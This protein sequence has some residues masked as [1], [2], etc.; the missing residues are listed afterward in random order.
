VGAGGSINTDVNFNAMPTGALTGN[1]YL[2]TDGVSLSVTGTGLVTFGQG[3][4]QANTA[5]NIPGEGLHPASNFLQLGAPSLTNESS[6]LTINFSQGVFAAGL[7]TIDKFSGGNM[8]IQAFTGAGGTGASLGT[9]SAV[10]S[11]FQE[12]FMYFM[13]LTTDV[14]FQ[15]LVFSYT[16]TSGDIIGI[17]NIEF[18]TVATVP[19]PIAGAGLPGLIMAGGGLLGWWRRRRNAATATAEQ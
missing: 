10:G 4:G 14:P 11:N 5:A 1:F 2:G 13:G 8:S 6:T 3:P 19:G 18:A 9:F 16:N 17:D 12:N 15:S 7:F